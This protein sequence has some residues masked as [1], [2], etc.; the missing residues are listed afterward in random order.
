MFGGE[1]WDVS[2]L[3]QAKID[4]EEMEEI[5]E[6]VG[7]TAQDIFGELPG[8]ISEGLG[9]NDFRSQFEQS[10][11]QAMQDAIINK[12]IETQA[13]EQQ[14]NQIA[15]MVEMAIG[16]EG[17]IYEDRLDAVQGQIDRVVER[18]GYINEVVKG[19]DLGIDTGGADVTMDRSFRA[20]STST[21]T[22]HNTFAVQSQIFLDDTSAAR[23]AAKKLA[24]YIQQYLE[25]HT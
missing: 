22:Y 16:S 24:P 10:I 20:G 14:I 2:G 11:G 18:A 5:L 13:I 15:G 12:L 25:R 17:Q 9:Y 19:L 8:L 1:D 21:I 3:G 6:R 23:E 7:Q 4:L